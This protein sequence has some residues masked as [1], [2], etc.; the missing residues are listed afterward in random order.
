MSRVQLVREVFDSFNAGE[1]EVNPDVTH[2]DIEVVTE[3]TRLSGEPY[4]GYAGLRQWIAETWDAF[5][6]WTISIGHVEEPSPARVL[7][8]G[9]LHL[10][11]RGSGVTVDL[12]C[13]WIFD[14]EGELCT[15]M[16]TFPNRV[17]EAR[18]AATG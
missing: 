2:P 11:G 13:G 1:F 4:C 16:E 6:E 8:V 9:T 7:V 14:F 15:R 10:V 12:P 18:R 17:D 3:A 5:E